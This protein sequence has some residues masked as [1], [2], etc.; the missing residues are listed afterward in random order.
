LG[1]S[2]INWVIDSGATDHMTWDQNKLQNII[3]TVEPQHILV[4]N[5]NKVQIKGLGTTKLLTKDIQNILYLPAFNSNLLSISKITRDLNCKVIFSPHEVIFQDQESGKK[6]GEDFFKNGLY[7]LKE[8]INK[9]HVS[10]SPINRETLLHW[11][12][13]HPSDQVLNNLFSY[14]LDSSNCDVCKLAKQIRLPFF[15]MY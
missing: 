12:F 9:C 7:Y 4:A 10:L 8:P 5:R 13:G 3:P 14:N 11:R 1:H 15:F 6:I 2:T